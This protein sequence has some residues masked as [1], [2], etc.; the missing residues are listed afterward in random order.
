MKVISVSPSME[1][2]LSSQMTTRLPSRCV[3][4]S[5][6]ASRL[7]PSWRS[8]SEAITQMV[9]SNGL[10]PSGASGSSS[11]RSRRAAIAMPTALAK[12]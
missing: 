2:W 12:P 1:M 10:R 7:T 11:P 8:P 6:A 5:E 9:W 4:A 3:P